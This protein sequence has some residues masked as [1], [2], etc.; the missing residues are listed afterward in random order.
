MKN[1]QAQTPQNLVLTQILQNFEKT[2]TPRENLKNINSN[3]IICLSCGGSIPP[4]APNPN[5][6]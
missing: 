4:P 6:P 2:S 3:L 5:R 1:Y